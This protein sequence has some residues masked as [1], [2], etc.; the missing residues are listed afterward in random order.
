[1]TEITIKSVLVAGGT[2]FLGRA[3]ARHLVAK[4]YSVT[5][6]SRNEPGGEYAGRWLRW[7]GRT[8]GADWLAALDGAAAVV[9]LAGRT[10]DCRKTP[11]RCDEI[12][13]SRED[14]VHAIGEA[15]KQCEQPPPVWVQAGTAHI[16][17]DPPDK[18][19]DE[20]TTPGY[21]LAPFVAE[22]WEDAFSTA[23]PADT[24]GVVLRTSFV[25]GNTGGALPVLTRLA[26]LMLGGTIGNGRQWISWLHIEDF[27]RIVERAITDDRM[28]GVYNVTSPKPAT[29]REF[30]RKL[31]RATG[32]PIG[33]P[34][35]SW[36]VR[37]AA[38]M[39][40]D[41]D[42][43]LVLFGRNIAPQRLNDMGY[44]FAFPSLDAALADLLAR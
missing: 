20:S 16:Y 25:I 15:M 39:L 3:V 41:T 34:A 10:V 28:Q 2:G 24:R 13:R 22:R 40:L 27:C 32:R 12:L 6:L 8:V 29:N 35:P 19:C 33:V 30:M 9:N 23:L 43:E 26:K 36:L 17:G 31:R 44:G 1:M 14:S 21:G 37:L 5:I 38:A 11:D 7:D 42:P 18:V 4:G